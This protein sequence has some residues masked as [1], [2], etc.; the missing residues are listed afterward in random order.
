MACLLRFI[1]AVA[2]FV[3]SWGT[4]A[5]AGQ[6]PPPKETAPQQ[7]PS[8]EPVVPEYEFF[9]GTIAE[10][11]EGR[12]VV[13]RAILGKPAESKSFLI[14][15]ETK[16]EGELK[17]N[18]RVTVGFKTTEEGDVAVRIIVRPPEKDKKNSWRH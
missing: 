16:I 6:N 17:N 12:I 2:L 8:P 18:A 11:S 4:Y 3:P 13:A 7:E 10:Y 14:T 5:I 1:L 9:S 15:G